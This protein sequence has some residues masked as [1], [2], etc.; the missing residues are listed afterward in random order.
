MSEE[1]VGRQVEVKTSGEIMSSFLTLKDPNS[2]TGTPEF[3]HSKEY[4]FCPQNPIRPLFLRVTYISCG[5][6]RT[7]Q[8]GRDR[9]TICCPRGDPVY[10]SPSPPL[11]WVKGFYN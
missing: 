1:D 9:Y 8:E 4:P 11:L 6:S 10:P 3:V 2:L 7:G 5:E